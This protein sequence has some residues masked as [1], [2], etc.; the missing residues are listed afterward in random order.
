MPA[1]FKISGKLVKTQASFSLEVLNGEVD[2]LFNQAQAE[3]NRLK[4][5][6]YTSAQAKK[7]II[8]NILSGDGFA[9]SWQ[10][11]FNRMISQIEKEAIAQPVNNYGASG[12]KKFVWV[13]GAVKTHHCQDCLR[14][15]TLP[16]KT[17]EEWR[18]EG[19]G[20]PREG[21]TE[22]NV[23]CQCML[24][25]VDVQEKQSNG[26]K[27]KPKRK[28][29][30]DVNIDENEKFIKEKIAEKIKYTGIPIGN[31]M[32][33]RIL[34]EIKLKFKD[35][36]RAGLL[37]DKKLDV[38]TI[39]GLNYGAGTG[40]EFQGKNMLDSNRYSIKISVPAKAEWY[41]QYLSMV[42]DRVKAGDWI[43]VSVHISDTFAHEYG[44]F[45]H[46]LRWKKLPELTAEE[47]FPKYYKN[48]KTMK[49]KLSRYSAWE[50]S[51][52]KGVYIEFPSEAT[53]RYFQK[54]GKSLPASVKEFVEFLLKGE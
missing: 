4:M 37:N 9:R 3:I 25:P 52:A 40:G 30:T 26:R 15:S 33:L 10:N 6:G 21:G 47:M 44:H 36:E 5:R 17:I 19:Y 11:R 12:N 43:K 20:L 29:S 49:E 46:D 34:N 32:K 41:D 24:A 54:G 8:N 42:R 14:L 23:G 39:N 27:N 13:L 22:C 50:Y 28:N 16:A 53:A 1:S 35:M 7:E 48:E 31:T 51:F 45:L 18:A 2:A 38:L